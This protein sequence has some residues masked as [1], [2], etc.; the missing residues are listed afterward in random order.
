MF[1]PQYIH[2]AVVPLRI[3]GR[4]AMWNVYPL[5]ELPAGAGTDGME[6]DADRALTRPFP[7]EQVPA[8]PPAEP[9]T[10]ET[11]TTQTPAATPAPSGTPGATPGPSETPLASPTP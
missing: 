9:A 6:P 1:F 8:L 5:Q 4:E 3:P 7:Y 10:G 11:E 2:E